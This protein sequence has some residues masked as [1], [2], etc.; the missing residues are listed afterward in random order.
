MPLY[1]YLCPTCHIKFEQ[2]HPINDGAVAECPE[3]GRSATRVLSLFA[4]YSRGAKGEV[5]PVAGGGG[6]CPAC[7]G[8][9]CACA[10]H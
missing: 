2:L 6:G 7:A 9:S 1:E 3:C 4:S 8:G 10:V 5:T